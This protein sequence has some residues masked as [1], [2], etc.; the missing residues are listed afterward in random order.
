M[1]LVLSFSVVGAG[2]DGSTG[3]C[4]A[5]E[6]GQECIYETDYGFNLY[7]K[8]TCSDGQIDPVTDKCS[9]ERVGVP[10]QIE[11]YYCNTYGQCHMMQ[12]WCPNGCLN[13]EC[14]PSGI[15]TTSATPGC[16]DED[17]GI[18]YDRQGTCTD[19]FGTHTE[20]CDYAKGYRITEYYCVNVTG[21]DGCGGG[22]C[23]DDDVPEFRCMAQG[24]RCSG[25]YCERG[26]CTTE[27]YMDSATPGCC[28]NPKTRPCDYVSNIRSCC[29]SSWQGYAAW[30]EPGPKGIFDC[31]AA[32]FFPSDSP[33]ACAAMAEAEHPKADMCGFGC[34][35]YK[36][37][38]D[39]I[40]SDQQTQSECTGTDKQWVNFGTITECT[41]QYCHGYFDGGTL[42][43]DP[44]VPT[45][46]TSVE[47]TPGSP[48]EDDDGDGVVNGI[49][50]CI[51][52][53]NSQNNID[54]DEFGDAC[55]PDMDNDG[56]INE[57]DECPLDITKSVK[58]CSDKQIAPLWFLAGGAL[59]GLIASFF[60][61]GATI[62]IGLLIGAILG[63]IALLLVSSL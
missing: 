16:Y 54:N 32:W 20:S 5:P 28:L 31:A 34:C 6:E 29:P 59:A 13:G 47:Y 36:T 21:G 45:T 41:P 56:I 46:T 27:L 53:F 33:E 7:L 2:C 23:G 42:A 61:P 10:V 25:G 35:C 38:S 58:P 18:F 49:D 48:Q 19:K 57:E 30:D 52:T 9:Q 40:R 63:L 12:K 22:V 43:D 51:N 39:E 8:G 60:I 11:E 15:P 17:G 24:T 50:N 37:P 14:L 4:D 62:I 44:D 26:A 55:D 3:L 1:A